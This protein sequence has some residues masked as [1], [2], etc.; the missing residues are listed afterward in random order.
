MQLT[1]ALKNQIDAMSYTTMLHKWRFAPLGDPLFQDESGD[2]FAARMKE[3]RAQ[4][5]DGE[6]VAA[7]KAIGWK[8]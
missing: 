4:I 6:H 2:Y 8:S 1:E 5:S 7:S 3:V